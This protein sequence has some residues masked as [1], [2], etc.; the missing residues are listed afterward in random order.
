MGRWIAYVETRP[1]TPAQLAEYHTWYDEVHLA[2]VVELDGFVSARRFEPVDDDG[3]FVA[4]YEIE[5]DDVE[6]AKISLRDAIEAGR[7]GRPPFVQGDPPPL[8]RYLKQR[9]TYPSK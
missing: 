7:V 1:T 4:V 8:V 3:P 6:V 2:E 9:A 5:A